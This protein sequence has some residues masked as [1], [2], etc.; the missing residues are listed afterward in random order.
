ML[1]ILVLAAGTA[2][3]QLRMALPDAPQPSVAVGQEQSASASSSSQ[4]QLQPTPP[5]KPAPGSAGSVEHESYTKRKWAQYVDPGEKVPRLSA[6]DKMDFW[7][8][9]ET[10]PWSA[11][12]ALLSAGWGQLTDGAPDYG[13]D[14][15]AFGE[16]F[17][18]ALVRQASFRFFSSSLFPA[19][20]GE[21]PRYY[22]K[23]EGSIRSRAI[24]AAERVLI[25]QRDSGYHSVNF[26]LIVGHLAASEL[27]MAWY[28][29]ASANQGVAM[30][31]W[32]TSLAG[33]AVN[34]MFLEF[35]P[36]AVNRWRRHRERKHAA[37]SPQA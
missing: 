33:A 30:E 22:R 9:E 7:L 31:T 35:W 21:D 17:G 36:D 23:A 20:D 11:G 10:Q 25:T 1:P 12:P 13:S 24:W 8:H 26:S 4:N 15:A 6:H 14:S 5:G 37:S 29:R 34:N 3:G 27:T 32:G 16:R 19:I 28:P 2:C 18:A